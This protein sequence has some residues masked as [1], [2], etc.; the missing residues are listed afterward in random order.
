M[1]LTS[2]PNE[3]LQYAS[4]LLS[5]SGTS[6]QTA[7]AA[8]LAQA[9]AMLRT[10]NAAN[11]VKLLRELAAD[12]LTEAGSEAAVTLG[13]YLLSQKKYADAAKVLED[14]TASASPHDYWIARAY[15]TLADTLAARGD[16]ASAR[17]YVKSL[18]ENYPGDEDDIRRMINTRLNNWK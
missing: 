4:L 18:K 14:F 12:P 5:S 9:S 2:D 16:K 11:G 13:E 15:I 6:P 1:L 10:G 3:S 7:A 17:E 8:R